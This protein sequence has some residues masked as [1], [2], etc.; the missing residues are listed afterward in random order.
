MKRTVV[1]F[2]IG[3]NDIDTTAA[4]YE[5]VFDWNLTK[6]GNS[7]IIDTG[8]VDALSGHINKLGPNDPQNYVTVYIETETLASDLK[9]IESNGGEVF[10][11]PIKLPDGREFAWFKDVA[12][13]LIG[14]ITPKS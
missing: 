5:A 1:H 12:G 11:K 2:E 9:A 13:N 4:F 10:V 14:L 6:H 8:K 3:C 7:A